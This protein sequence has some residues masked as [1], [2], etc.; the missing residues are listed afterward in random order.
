MCSTHA[1]ARTHTHNLEA[2]HQ[3]RHLREVFAKIID[4]HLGE[5]LQRLDLREPPA[6]EEHAREMRPGSHQAEVRGSMPA[7]SRTCGSVHVSSLPSSKRCG[8]DHS[9]L[10]SPWYSRLA[11]DS[12]ASLLAPH[13]HTHARRADTVN[14][15]ARPQDV[16]HRRAEGQAGQ[17][18]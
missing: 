4:G 1:R 16:A 12:S 10:Y 15:C 8:D 2:L 18:D 6:C 11:T 17:R 5:P 7:K 3:F 14:L 13:A 9:V